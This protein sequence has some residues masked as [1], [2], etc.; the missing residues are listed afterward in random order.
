[1]NIIMI[2]GFIGNDPETKTVGT[3]TVTNFSVATNESWTDKDGQKQQR[4]TWHRCVAWGKQGEI[5]E[6]YFSKGKPIQVTGSIQKRD[7]ETDGG[8]KRQAVDIRVTSFNFVPQSKTGN[9][10]EDTTST[11]YQRPEGVEN[12]APTFDADETIPF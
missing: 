3:T 5:I 10:T 8:E 11:P 6:K 7:Y 2:M 12:H 4:T 1:M 9:P